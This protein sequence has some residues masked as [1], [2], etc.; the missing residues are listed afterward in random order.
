MTDLVYLNGDYLPLADAKIPVLD[1]GFIFGDGVYEV[2]PV[3][4]R[5]PFRL[6][7]HLE[8]L[9]HSLDGIRLA[10]PHTAEAWQALIAPL[11]EQA[12]WEDQGIYL[13]VTRGPAPRDHAFPKEVRPTVFVMVMQLTTPPAA[14]VENGVAAITA[15]DNRWL[16]CD[17]KATSLLANVLLR[18]LSVDAGCAETILLRDGLLME[19]SASSIF[20]VKDGVVLAPPHSNLVLPGITYDVV[21]ELAQLEGLPLALRPVTEAELRSADEI[22]L[23]SSTKEITAVTRLDGHPVGNGRPGPLFRRLHAAYQAYKHQVMRGRSTPSPLV[24][25]GTT[26]SPSPAS[27]GGQGWWEP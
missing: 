18:Q 14:V 2:I 8:R 19:G 13:Q 7:H 1:R 9:Q 6:A 5:R 23:T 15:I 26:P 22:W 20:V 4:D 27:G 25:E 12:D 21:V 24:G 11:V 10:N 17:L 3:Y 16:R